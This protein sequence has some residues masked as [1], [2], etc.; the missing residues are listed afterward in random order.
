MSRMALH[1]FWPESLEGK[2]CCSLRRKTVGGTALEDE[3]GLRNECKFPQAQDVY[4][5]AGR[6]SQ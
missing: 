3:D 1:V 6:Y 5:I 4:S 2:G